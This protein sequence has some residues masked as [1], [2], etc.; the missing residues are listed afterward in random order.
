MKVCFVKEPYVTELTWRSR[1][2]AND[3][4]SDFLFRSQNWGL[5]HAAEADIWVIEP[6]ARASDIH[7]FLHVHQRDAIDALY[8]RHEWVQRSD[9][10]WGEYDVVITLDSIAEPAL[11]GAFPR[12]LW[13]YF[14]QEHTLP[15]YGRSLQA[16]RTGYDLFLDHAL[17][18][19]RQFAAVPAPVAFPYCATRAAF[20][21]F[22]HIEKEPAAYLDSHLI[23][24]QD[25]VAL[26]RRLSA[27][28]GVDVRS[29]DPWDFAASFREVGSGRTSSPGDYL[30]RLAA[31]RYFVLNRGGARSIGQA[32][33]EAAALDVIVLA[34]EA[35]TY[36]RELCHPETTVVAHDSQSVAAVIRRLEED[37]DFRAAVLNHQRARLDDFFVRR[38]LEVLETAVERKREARKPTEPVARPLR[39]LLGRARANVRSAP[40]ELRR[41]AVLPRAG[42]QPQP[43]RRLS[44][45][46]S[47]RNDDYGGGFVERATAALAR[48][49]SEGTARGIECELI[50]VE[51]NPLGEQ[52]LSLDL[53]QRGIRC[54]VVAPEIH[55]RL[56][57]PAVSDRLSF[58]QFMAKNVGIRR[59]TGEHILVTN[60]DCVIGDNVWDYLASTPLERHLMYRAVRCDVEP[61]Y[62]VDDFETL[63]Q[64]TL[65]RHEAANGRHFTNA[66]GDFVLFAAERR[67]GYDERITFSDA[68][69]DGRFCRQW[70]ALQSRGDGDNHRLFRFIG[71]VFKAEHPLTFHHT[72]ADARHPKGFTDWWTDIRYGSGSGLYENDA[73]WGLAG[74]PE[75]QVVPGVTLIG[76]G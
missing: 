1:R 14:E 69:V 54:F 32:S 41:R 44:I 5:V 61:R 22:A 59:A 20:A 31:C 63:R 21:R 7:T 65:R 64:K 42:E 8:E 55:K 52:Y 74:E 9:V 38:S 75:H 4:L 70:S 67:L 51:W 3:V 39:S 49:A 29:A 30:A 58:F 66:A 15:S 37:A 72:W 18:A 76:R 36:G 16:P 23:R 24:G 27:E 2:F 40:R 68:H 50:F 62:F 19:P 57:S 56:V 60:A 47:G 11:T 33:I 28:F 45:V 35:Q 17:A 12:T 46:V 10:P 43:C 48:N 53:A 13:C 25:V 73:D 26:R 6:G 34:D 71:D